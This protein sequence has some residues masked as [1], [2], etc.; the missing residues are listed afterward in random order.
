M[1]FGK[2]EN[3]DADSEPCLAFAQQNETQGTMSVQQGVAASC[4]AAFP[5]SGGSTLL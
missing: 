2:P 5:G 4:D 1:L 3:A